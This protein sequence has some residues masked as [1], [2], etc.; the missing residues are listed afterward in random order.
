MSKHVATISWQRNGEDFLANKYSRMHSWKFDGGAHVQASASP[1]IVPL[2]W[3]SEENVDPE[4]AFVASVSSCHMLFF[5]SIAAERGIQ[6]E[7]YNDEVVGRMSKNENGKYAISQ[8]TL[9]PS[10][11]YSGSTTPSEEDER[12]IHHDAHE[13]CFIANSVTSEIRIEIQR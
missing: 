9:H 10:V 13:Q 12:A 8:I 5:L 7:S 6:V 3:S 11:G 1:Q 4:E 2:P